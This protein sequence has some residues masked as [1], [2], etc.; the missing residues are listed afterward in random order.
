MMN[1]RYPNKQEQTGD[2]VKDF[3]KTTGGIVLA[4]VVGLA[5]VLALIFA[6]LGISWITAPFKGATEARNQTVGNGS[7]R[8]AAYDSFF[9]ECA[10]AKTIQQN[11]ANT[12]QRL[13]QA[14]KENDQ[15][16]IYL[17]ETNLQAQQNALN[18][19]VNQYNADAHKADTKAHFL[20]STLPYTLYATQE[21]QCAV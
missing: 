1:H 16:A 6:S 4:C 7:Y 15:Q 21:I 8:I 3:F 18:E 2:S 17:Q 11:L 5:L 12:K 14:R 19:A 9:D 13:K 20:A 10:T